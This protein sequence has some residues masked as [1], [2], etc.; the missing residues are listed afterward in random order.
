MA[1]GLIALLD[2]VAA[3]TRLAAASLDDVALAAGKASKKAIG[4]VIDDAAVTPRYVVGL[5]AKREIPIIAKIARGSLINKLLILLP[6]ALALSALAPWAITPLLMLGGL[7][8][9]YEAAHKV[10]EV[11]FANPN[12]T[13][14]REEDL[15]DL[16]ALEK[17]KIASA[18]RTDFILSAEIMAIALS[19]IAGQ[20]LAT[21]AIILL[22]VGLGITIGVYGTVALIVKM[23]DFGLYL[24]GKSQQLLQTIG[25]GLVRAMPSI[26]LFLSVVGTAAMAWVGGGILLHGLEHYHMQALPHFVHALA[27]AAGQF[28][29]PAQKL[30]AWVVNALGAGLVGLGAGAMV[31][32]ALKGLKLLKFKS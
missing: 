14:H 21:Q 3:L 2:D 32:A 17:A 7:F 24:T 8:L 30:V 19:D 25:R 26:M 9:C 18:V 6:A 12:T 27:N 16:A 4:V 1:T 15:T 29:Q 20:P 5:A 11:V 10:S 23:D 31:L 28:V 13:E 22:I